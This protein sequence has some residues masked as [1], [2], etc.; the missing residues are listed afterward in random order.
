MR[1][2]NQITCDICGG[3]TRVDLSMGGCEEVVRRHTCLE[4]GRQI[5]T[6]ESEIDQEKFSRLYNY[7]RREYSKRSKEKKGGCAKND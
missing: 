3:K 6:L 2:R 7:Y 4:C 5:Y 1:V